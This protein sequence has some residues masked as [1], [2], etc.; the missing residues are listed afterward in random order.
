VVDDYIICV[1]KE[2]KDN[3]NQDWRLNFRKR[4]PLDSE[5][6]KFYV[7]EAYKTF[8]KYIEHE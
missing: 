3:L 2:M 6:A 4:Y 8:L 7:K 5:K 1:P